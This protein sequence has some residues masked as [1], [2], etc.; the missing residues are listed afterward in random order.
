VEC[1]VRKKRKPSVVEAQASRGLTLFFCSHNLG[2]IDTTFPYCV[3]AGVQV[4]SVYDV[5]AKRQI[6]LLDL[7]VLVAYA[8]GDMLTRAGDPKR[9]GKVRRRHGGA[10]SVRCL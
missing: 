10:S 7:I 9:G 2:S 3:V 8:K 4:E 6:F 5:F 1:E